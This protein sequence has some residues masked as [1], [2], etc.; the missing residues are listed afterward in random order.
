MSHSYNI[1]YNN[2]QLYQLFVTRNKTAFSKHDVLLLLNNL[3]SFL[4]TVNT[5]HET[6]SIVWSIL[7]RC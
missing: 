5:E 2:A 4:E 7:D 3:D 1:L 6:Y